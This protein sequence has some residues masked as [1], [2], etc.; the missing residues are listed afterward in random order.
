MVFMMDESKVTILVV[1]DVLEIRSLIQR[2]LKPEGF[3][4]I[5]VENGHDAVKLASRLFFDLLI[6]DAF[7]PTLK[8]RKLSSMVAEHNPRLKVMFLS[9]YHPQILASTG[10]C[11]MDTEILE[12][13]LNRNQVLAQVR[14][15]LQTGKTWNQLALGNQVSEKS[16]R[17]Q[18]HPS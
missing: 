15:V 5:G 18:S 11:P 17:P 8:S 16:E 7:L 14:R 1:D 9:N 2:H 13:P 3:L 4:V 10:L 12:V 6:V